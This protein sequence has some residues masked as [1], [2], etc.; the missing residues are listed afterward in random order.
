MLASS[1]VSVRSRWKRLFQVIS[2]SQRQDQPQVLGKSRAHRGVDFEVTDPPVV[3]GA[4]LVNQSKINKP[5]QTPADGR[6]RTK[7][8]QEQPLDCQQASSFLVIADFDNKRTIK[9]GL[10]AGELF[11]LECVKSSKLLKHARY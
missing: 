10:K 2:A 6:R 1:S 9:R 11:L 8:Q 7:F 3:V 5:L 4:T